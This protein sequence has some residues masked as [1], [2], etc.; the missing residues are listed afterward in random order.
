MARINYSVNADPEVTS[1]AMGSELH[2]SPKKSRE[3]CWKIKG[4]KAVE[5]R[6][7]LED[8]IALK[9]AV[10]F[11]RHS[12]GA[13]HRKGPMAGGRYPVNASKE[14]LKIL[15]NA[16]SNAEYKGLE[17]SNM[18]IAHVAINRGRVIHGF[19]PRARGRATP[20]NTDTV[21]IEMILSEVR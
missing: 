1:K 2:I 13:G 8:V 10:P 9:Q 16:E 14:I 3:I 20:K 15:R 19:I 5:A 12:E 21:N 4:M 18:Y 6:K 17:P 11:K 7:Y